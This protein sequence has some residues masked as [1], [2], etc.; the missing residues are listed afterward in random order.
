MA[1]KPTSSSKRPAAGGRAKSRASQEKTDRPG[2]QKSGTAS[3][4]KAKK[5]GKKIYKPKA[6]GG[7]DR[8][9]KAP[10]KPTI[11]VTDGSTRLNRY[12]SNS[13]VCSRREADTLIEAGV[14]SVN[15]K[16]IT[17]LGTRVMPGDV[18]KLEGDTLSQEKKRYLLL[19]KPKNFVTSMDDTPGKRTV[20]QLLKNSTRELLFPVGKLDRNTTGLL[21][22]TNDM[23]IAKKLTHPGQAIRKIYHVTTDH[24]VQIQHVHAMREGVQ[25]D[26]GLAK[27]VEIDYVGNGEDAKQIGIEIHSGKKNL[28]NRMFESFGYDVVKLDLV[29]FAGLTKKDLPRGRWR[30]LSEQEVGF[31]KM[32]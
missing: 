9:K 14:V 18:V 7:F 3:G 12:I 24:K 5:A 17:E 15:D 16:I 4:A 13:G 6:G 26:D 27:A 1:K 8:A 2:I 32:L 29:T 28:V 22:F 30:L 21:L 25:L 10:A 20:M 23:D 31:L 11:K 19:N